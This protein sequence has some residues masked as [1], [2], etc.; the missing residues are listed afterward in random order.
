MEHENALVYNGFSN[1]W[2]CSFERRLKA[3]QCN[4]SKNLV[5]RSATALETVVGFGASLDDSEWDC[6][7]LNSK[8][9][10]SCRR[11]C[12]YWR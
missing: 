6:F 10:P 1:S 3:W 11:E 2:S 5:L 4:G 12:S 7:V 8:G 9:D